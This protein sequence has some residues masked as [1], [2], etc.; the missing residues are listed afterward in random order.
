MNEL[1]Y[2][3]SDPTCVVRDDGDDHDD[4][5]DDDHCR[6]RRRRRCRRRPSQIGSEPQRSN[7]GTQDAM[8]IHIRIYV[9]T[10]LFIML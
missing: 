10:Y 6:R 8:Y 1:P 7:E 3:G 2:P 5:E 9:Y 4:H